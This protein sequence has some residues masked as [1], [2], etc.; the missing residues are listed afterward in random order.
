M[1]LKFGNI[2]QH[3]GG[4]MKFYSL[5]IQNK[6]IKNESAI[7][8]NSIHENKVKTEN[9]KQKRGEKDGAWN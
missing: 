3:S 5:V 9:N 8:E 1:V 7:L 6:K 2:F 4:C